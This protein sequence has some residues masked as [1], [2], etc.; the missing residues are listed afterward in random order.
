MKIS[1]VHFQ[2]LDSQTIDLLLVFLDFTRISECFI[3]I[4]Y[5]NQSPQSE[6]FR[7]TEITKSILE[8]N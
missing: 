3:F 1:D 2:I 6:K 4:I 7:K 8:S 5:Q